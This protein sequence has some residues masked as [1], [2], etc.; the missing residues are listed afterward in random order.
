MGSF[1]HDRQAGQFLCGNFL[2]SQAA[3]Q[4]QLMELLD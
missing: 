2:I 1:E 4:G 3:E